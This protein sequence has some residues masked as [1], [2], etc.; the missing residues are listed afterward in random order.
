M[1]SL[2]IYIYARTSPHASMC[3]REA[4]S[5]GVWIVSFAPCFH[6]L[7]YWLGLL[8]LQHWLLHQVIFLFCL[9]WLICF[10]TMTLHTCT[11]K[12]KLWDL[13]R[14]EKFDFSLFSIINYKM[15]LVSTIWSLQCIH[16]G[17]FA[18]IETILI[19]LFLY[20]MVTEIPVKVG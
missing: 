7:I 8:V 1:N 17:C 11:L 2:C 4:L 15:T 16:I 19:Q 5:S 20:T 18:Y 6:D 10:F 14:D 13:T 3:W 12:S 9:S